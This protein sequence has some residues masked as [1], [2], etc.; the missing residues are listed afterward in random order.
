MDYSTLRSM[1][2]V[3]VL[4][5][6]LTGLVPDPAHATHSTAGEVNT[7]RPSLGDGEGYLNFVSGAEYTGHTNGS[8][9]ARDG[10][11]DFADNWITIQNILVTDSNGVAAGAG[12]LNNDLEFSRKVYAQAGI[13]VRVEGSALVD[14]TDF[15]GIGDFPFSDA[16]I[17]ALRNDGSGR[18]ANADTLN[19][20][21]VQSF[22]APNPNG[23]TTAPRLAT[24]TMAPG[25]FLR[26]GRANSTHPHELGHMLFNGPAI[27][28]EVPGSTGHSSDNTNFIYIDASNAPTTLTDVGPKIGAIG[29]HS[30]IERAQIAAIHGNPGNGN[31]GFV[32]H[33]NHIDTHGDRADFD[34]VTDQR[35]IETGGG[36]NGAD[37]EVGSDWLI[38]EIKPGEVKASA[39]SGPG[40][41]GHAH[42]VSGLERPGYTAASFNTV[43]VFSNINQYADNDTPGGVGAGEAVR[44]VKALDYLIPEF[45]PDGSSWQ[46]GELVNTFRPGWTTGALSDDFVSRYKTDI[47]AK[48]VRIAA[49][50]LDSNGHDGNTQI[51]A[52][53]AHTIV[54]EDPWIP[55]VPE[56][57][58]DPGID[59]P[60]LDDSILIQTPEGDTEIFI[61][62]ARFFNETFTIETKVPVTA[63]ASIIGDNIVIDISLTAPLPDAFF[64]S[65]NGLDMLLNF[66]FLGEGTSLAELPF[67]DFT[68][69]QLPFSPS[70]ETL[71]GQD[72]ADTSLMI[73][74]DEVLHP[75][76][77]HFASISLET[78]DGVDLLGF[79]ANIQQFSGISSADAEIFLS[80]AP[81]VP[82]GAS[83]LG[84]GL[85]VGD[86]LFT[87]TIATATQGVVPE[88][89]SL[90]LLGTGIFC[91]AGRRQRP[92][93]A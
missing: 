9:T 27:H 50:A 5:A 19:V 55:W 10:G 63:N 86:S 33:S 25:V 73:V 12:G 84:D 2:P 59:G 92:P 22:D 52:I 58:L 74:P 36:A 3:F 38:W 24:V 39:H 81:P 85:A 71:V 66:D 51:D 13:A 91:L 46:A 28:M 70:F 68:N 72:F 37:I 61:P 18:S 76:S 40:G 35:I 93:A 54:P 32:K 45:S 44:R 42:K 4:T 60:S 90:V 16:E 43:D 65:G 48:F 21:Y 41:D 6:G 8:E 83:L 67:N 7:L 1:L 57:I 31:P 14:S 69:S 34:W 82:D 20:Y 15:P 62:D 56:T 29:N 23:I 79:Q 87:L 64:E 49:V 89:A 78:A 11:Q 75:D 77:D 30:I 53:L 26:D 17:Q 80:L 88:P 47:E